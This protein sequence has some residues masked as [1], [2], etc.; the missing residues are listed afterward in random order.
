ME[1]ANEQMRCCA[2]GPVQAT[3]NFIASGE[4]VHENFETNRWIVL[5]EKPSVFFLEPYI[6]IDR[7][8]I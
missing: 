6:D 5:L 2:L 8:A 3:I 1:P 7:P 4:Q